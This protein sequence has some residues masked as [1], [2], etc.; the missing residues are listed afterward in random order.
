MVCQNVAISQ[1]IDEINIDRYCH[2]KKNINTKYYANFQSLLKG[3]K[4]RENY[5]KYLKMLSSGNK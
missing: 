5:I 1:I 4:R 3:K 2:I